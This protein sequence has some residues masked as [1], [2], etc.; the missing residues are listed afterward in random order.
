MTPEIGKRVQA[1]PRHVKDALWGVAGQGWV[2]RLDGAAGAR[3]EIPDADWR[4]S[5]PGWEWWPANPAF[6]VAAILQI[7]LWDA[8]RRIYEACPRDEGDGGGADH[9]AALDVIE[10]HL[11]ERA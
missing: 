1:L 11:R 6:G 10:A 9:I 7:P 3:N 2:V 4:K 8:H 5:L